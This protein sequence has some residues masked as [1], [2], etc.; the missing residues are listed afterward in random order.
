MNPI[1]EHNH[2]I[3]RAT[4]ENNP[5]LA[6]IGKVKDFLQGVVAELGMRMLIPP[7]V[8]YCDEINNRGI[9]GLIGLTTSHIALHIWDEVSPAVIQLDVYTCSALDIDM[10]QSYIGEWFVIYEQDFLL[11]DRE[12]RIKIMKKD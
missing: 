2:Y 5:Q 6:D 11:L 8:A 3:L 7:Q 9:T 1:L 10:L 12:K 4:V